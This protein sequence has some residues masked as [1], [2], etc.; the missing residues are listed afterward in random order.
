[1]QVLPTNDEIVHLWI[2]RKKYI[3]KIDRLMDKESV[4]NLLNHR[5]EVNVYLVKKVRKPLPA[6]TAATA[7][8]AKFLDVLRTLLWVKKTTVL[9]VFFLTYIVKPFKECKIL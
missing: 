1:M 5:I 2:L 6:E 8:V 7:A 4:W 3:L 9:K